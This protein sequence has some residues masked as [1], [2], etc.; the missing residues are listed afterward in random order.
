MLGLQET[1]PVA[2]LRERRATA[3]AS[4][5]R[6]TTAPPLV[7]RGTQLR[8]LAE[9]LA[10]AS[11]GRPN[12]VLVEGAAGSGKTALI[13]AFAG[14]HDELRLLSACADTSERAVPFGVVDQLLRRARACDSLASIPTADREQFAGVGLTLLELL[15]RPHDGSPLLLVLDDAHCADPGSL[16]ALLFAMRR[17]VSEAVLVILTARTDCLHA[18]PDGLL[19]DSDSL[20]CS[21]I[22]LDPL[23]FGSVR[24][25]AR[26]RGLPLSA[27]A[28]RRVHD[29]SAGLP[30]HVCAL[31]DEWSLTGDVESIRAPRSYAALIHGRLS[32]CGGRAR[33]LV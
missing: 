6:R 20:R 5:G 31:L 26:H 4:I 22:F 18:L 24:E 7:G 21:R 10:G 12:V 9:A 16:R 29:L 13:R 17:L 30:L 8:R 3:D 25:L 2:T 11:S 1:A 14:E 19:R 27:R 23:D 32:Q 15:G 28:L 33:R